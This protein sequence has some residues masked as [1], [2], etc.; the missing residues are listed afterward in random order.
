MGNIEHQGLEAALH[1]LATHMRQVSMAMLTSAQAEMITS[2]PGRSAGQVEY[3]VRL[4]QHA[5]ELIGAA[6]MVEGWVEGVRQCP[7]QPSRP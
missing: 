1:D 5:V 2:G 3:E 4:A 6:R 7:G